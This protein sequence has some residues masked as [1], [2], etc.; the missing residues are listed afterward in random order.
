MQIGS[1]PPTPIPRGERARERVLRAALGVLADDGMPGFTME[2]V[3]QRAGASKATLYRRWTSRAALLVDAMELVS[4]PFAPPDTGGV[5]SDLL[6]M[7]SQFEAMLGA[8]SFPR[9]MAAFI[10]AAE[11]DPTLWSLHQQITER[12]REPLLHVLARA[13]A[14]GEIPQAADLELAADL[15]AGPAF[16]RRF[17]AHRPLPDGYGAAVVDHVLMALRRSVSRA[18]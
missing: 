1:S 3:A 18:D 9:L 5:R 8:R 16:Y 2:A 7:M 15:L 4:E 13:Q 11:R 10:D 12:R 6:E 14:R 17:I